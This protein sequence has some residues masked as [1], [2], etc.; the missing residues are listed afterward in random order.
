MTVELPIADHISA[1]AMV[2]A[3]ITALREQRPARVVNTR[4]ARWRI[5]AMAM[6]SWC[7]PCTATTP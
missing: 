7:S 4:P 2:R 6:S 1:G 3:A 5:C